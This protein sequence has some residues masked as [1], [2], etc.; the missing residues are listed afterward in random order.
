VRKGYL[1]MEWNTLRRGHKDG[2]GRLDGRDVGDGRRPRRPVG[3]AEGEGRGQEGPRR[4]RLRLEGELQLPR[5][6][7]D[8]A[9]HRDRGGSGSAPRS[10]GSPARRQAVMEQRKYRPRAWSGIHGFGSGWRAE[11]AFS[12]TRR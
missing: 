10:G 11:G 9:G 4:R 3:D 5:G 2:A 6:G 12:A 7:G 1:K 8:G